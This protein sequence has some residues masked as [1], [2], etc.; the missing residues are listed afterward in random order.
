MD[1]G[2][3]FLAQQH[4]VVWV[5]GALVQT[6]LAHLFLVMDG[7]TDPSSALMAM[8]AVPPIQQ[9]PDISERILRSHGLYLEVR[10]FL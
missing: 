4:A 6:Q 9:V 3:A 8:D 5:I 2:M 10:K 7:E 1:F